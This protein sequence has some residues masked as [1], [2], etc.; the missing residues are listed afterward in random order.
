ADE[1]RHDADQARTQTER[2]LER[3]QDARN[4]LEKVLSWHRVAMAQRAYEDGDLLRARVLLNLC[5]EALRRWE[6]HSVHRQCHEELPN[7]AIDDMPGSVRTLAF[8]PDG[9]HLAIATG[10]SR[11]M[12]TW[13]LAL[14]QNT[15][16]LLT[17]EEPNFPLLAISA[18]GKRI[19]S[20]QPVSDP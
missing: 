2:A 4:K 9:R 20:E 19:A 8:S 3:E 14:G 10:Q 13:D 16:K 11:E 1:A 15:R 17:I 6:W 7:I 18:D 5:P 12:Q